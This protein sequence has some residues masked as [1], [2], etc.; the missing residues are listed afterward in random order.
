MPEL[1]FPLGA[2]QDIGESGPRL[3]RPRRMRHRGRGGRCRPPA[4][5]R[6]SRNPSARS[7]LRALHDGPPPG[8]VDS[9]YVD[10][11][12]PCSADMWRRRPSLRSREQIADSN[13]VGSRDPRCAW[14]GAHGPCCKHRAADPHS[15]G[16]GSSACPARPGRC[17]CRPEPCPHRPLLGHLPQPDGPCRAS[18]PH[19]H[20]TLFPPPIPALPSMCIGDPRVPTST[21]S[22]APQGVRC[23]RSP[24]RS[25]PWPAVVRPLSLLDRSVSVS[26]SRISSGDSGGRPGT[27]EQECDRHAR[28]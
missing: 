18:E 11:R 27:H 12:A 22:D 20:V 5:R 9:R 23:G 19:A 21:S 28:T 24:T 7:Q 14:R 16:P 25:A 10:S 1:R 8:P 17:G 2:R 13:T 15:Q 6:R 4:G 26:P 3:P